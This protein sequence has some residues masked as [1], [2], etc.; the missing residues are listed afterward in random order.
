M[1]LPGQ[2]SYESRVVA[3]ATI[4]FSDP[5]N[6][7]VSK[8]G[9]A[10]LNINPDSISAVVDFD[11]LGLISNNALL[12]QIFFNVQAVENFGSP[13]QITRLYTVGA[14]GDIIIQLEKPTGGAYLWTAGNTAVLNVT[15]CIVDNGPYWPT[16]NP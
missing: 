9:F 8:F 10:K 2:V 1:T 15:V 5:N 7:G 11:K 4:D 12:G 16:S 6:P 13:P 14:P 3:L